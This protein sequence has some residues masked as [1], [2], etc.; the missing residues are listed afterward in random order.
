MAARSVKA[1]A[2]AE[3][4]LAHRF[5]V[6]RHVARHLG[7]R[8]DQAHVV[9]HIDQLRQLVEQL[10]RSQRPT[11][12]MRASCDAVTSGRTI[13]DAHGAETWMRNSRPARPTR[14]CRNHTGPGESS[15]TASAMNAISG[16]A[17]G[18]ASE[19][20]P[21]I[22]RLARSCAGGSC[23]RAVRRCTACWRA[24]GVNWGRRRYRR[25][26]MRWPKAPSG[27]KAAEHAKAVV[28]GRW[29]KVLCPQ[30]PAVAA[31][32]KARPERL[33]R[34]AA[35]IERQQPAAGAQVLGAQRSSVACTSARRLLCVR[36]TPPSTDFIT[37]KSHRPTS[38]RKSRC[39]Q[40]MRSASADGRRKGAGPQSRA[41]P[42]RRRRTL[43]SI[44]QGQQQR[45]A[46]NV[47]RRPVP[48]HRPRADR[49][50][51][52]EKRAMARP[53]HGRSSRSTPDPTRRRRSLM[54]ETA[55]VT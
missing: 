10:R 33:Q 43:D 8:T 3:N 20:A 42:L 35:V 26:S 22:A 27:R 15:F 47:R 19:Q 54:P 4:L 16:T 45:C 53:R 9:Q 46:K 29:R 49:G 44:G 36:C 28:F 25:S 51:A 34:G 50:A 14:S 18:S 5:G 38:A 23:R 55:L 41:A 2:Q 52:G 32:A 48:A 6:Q 30:T 13:R 11:R 12:V 1:G 40:C 24:S 7:P 31:R 37:I 17:S 39:D 21:S